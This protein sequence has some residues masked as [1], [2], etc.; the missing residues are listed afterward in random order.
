MNT[1][2]ENINQSLESIENMLNLQGVSNVVQDTVPV[3]QPSA[4]VHSLFPD[5]TPFFKTRM[6]QTIEDVNQYSWNRGEIGG[7]DWGYETFNK[8]FEGL[9]TGVHLIAGQSNV[10][11]SGICMQLAQQIAK[12]NQI[13]TPQRPK[14]AFVVYF[15]LDDSNNELLPRYIAIDQR[16]PINAVR[17][18][19]KYKDD[20]HL[21]ERREIGLENLKNIT[22]HLAMHDVNDGS[23]IEYIEESAE[24][25]FVELQKIDEDYQLVLIIDNFHD[26][27]VREAK[28]GADSTG[29]YDHIA[30]KL[31]RLATRFDCPII[32]TAEFRKLNGNRRPIL[33]DIRESTKIV[34]EAK[35]I[36]LCYNEVGLRGQQANIF[37]QSS[38]RPDKRP[39][40]EAHVGKN[41]FGSFKG[42]MFFEFVPEQSYFKEVP[43]AQAIQYAQRITG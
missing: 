34:Y 19:K 16:I 32:C 9:N 21:M 2:S 31:T 36:L 20:A 6:L 28:F 41:K 8:A 33:D 15:S 13:P 12:A 29:K 23:D 42:R 22:D 17:F 11:K 24:K 1:M 30:D 7:L 3:N 18:P 39:V 38:D 4:S 35:A 10:G 43:S 26:I 25:Y 40:F 5:S 27:T 37:W 14:K